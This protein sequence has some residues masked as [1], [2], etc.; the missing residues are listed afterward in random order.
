MALTRGE[1]RERGLIGSGNTFN[2]P[3]AEGP[4]DASSNPSTGQSGDSEVAMDIYGGQQT[5]I[6][7]VIKSNDELTALFTSM[8]PAR[9]MR[10][11]FRRP[12]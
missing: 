10:Y 4:G 9:R 2:E 7:E 1:A 5:T 3:S 12:G 6:A 8:R 11:E